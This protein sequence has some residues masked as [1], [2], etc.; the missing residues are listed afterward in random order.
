[1]RVD[2]GFVDSAPM[3]MMSAPIS[4]SS[5]RAREGAV[6]VG[7]LPAVGERIRGDVEDPEHHRPLAELDLPLF[8]FPEIK[9]SHRL[10][11]SHFRANNDAHVETVFGCSCPSVARVFTPSRYQ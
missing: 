2:P 11:L 9:L 8:Q 6:R 4:S 1:M 10:L 7:I 5:M 3:S